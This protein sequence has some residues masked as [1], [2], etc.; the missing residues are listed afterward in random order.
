MILASILFLGLI[1]RL[2]S[3]NQSLWL[4]EAINVLA[5]KRFGL[6][7]MLTTYAQADFHPPGYFFILWIWTKAF[8]FSEISV[9]IPS[10]IFSLLT[11]YIIYLIGRKLFT[12]KTGLL[13]AL[14]LAI[15]PL[16]IY[17]S[18]EARMYSFSALAVSLSFFLF[19]KLL[20]SEK[21]NLFL[22]I[23]TN[24][25]VLS[26]DYVA[27][28][29]F[30]AELL[31]LLILRI[32]M[33]MIKKWIISLG[34]SL[35]IMMVWLPIFLAQINNGITLTTNIPFWKEVVGSM[36]LKA[37][38]LTFVK[39]I[40]GR[41]SI[42]DKL[43][44]LLS[45]TPVGLIFT[46]LIYKG[47]NSMEGFA[48]KILSVWII[49]PIILGL[50]ISVFTPVYSYFR[51]L[52]LLIPFVIFLAAGINCFNNRLKKIAL[53]L[54]ITIEL[55]CSLIYLFNPGFQ[56]ED[57]K[58]LAN[59]IKTNKKETKILL[60]SNGLFSPLDYYSNDK[61]NLLP[62]L[63]NFPAESLMDVKGLEEIKDLREIYLVE[64][65]VDIADPNRLVAQKLADLGFIRKDILNFNGIGFVYHYIK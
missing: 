11:I 3:I 4:D 56:R 14:L 12:R 57:W 46:Y 9:R 24:L 45:F 38:A 65:L 44:Y 15:N 10:V 41:I 54:I 6:W 48:K 55:G 5:A 31:L 8:G 28:L 19:I 25:L 30:P 64:Y 58:G 33:I 63:N 50:L 43:L 42:E 22:L 26:S 34:I 47:F 13:C 51:V 60:E 16:H 27:Y 23:L 39:F 61:I 59:F 29:I 18:Q 49:V 40:I 62:A 21:V 35:L 37:L 20:K 2:I 53:V 17:Y 36:G 7:E 1:L 32:N 52:Y